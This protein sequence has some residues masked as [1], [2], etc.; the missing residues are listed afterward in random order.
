VRKDL[1]PTA[2]SVARKPGLRHAALGEMG[3][4]VTDDF[5][6]QFGHDQERFA[7]LGGYVYHA[8]VAPRCSAAV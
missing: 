2:G 4:N 6:E 7:D 3:E 8:R 1:Q 5:L